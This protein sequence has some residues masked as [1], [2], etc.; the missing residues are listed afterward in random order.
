MRKLASIQRVRDVVEH[1]N[2]DAL[3]IAKV[4]GWQCIIKKGEMQQ[5]DLG[6]YF[7]IDSFLPANDE[8]YLFLEKTFRTFEGILGA[9]IKTIKLRGELSQGLILPLSSYPELVH[10]EEGT[11]VTE[12]LG[13]LKYE[14]P[15]PVS[16][17]AKGNFPGFIEKT[18]QE[19]IQNLTRM[20]RSG[21][22]EKTEKLD[23]SSLTVYLND[24]VFGVCS[25]NMELIESDT[26]PMWLIAREY[27]LEGKLR[28]LGK[29][30][31]L[32]GEIIGGKI[33]GNRYGITGYEYHIYDVYDIENKRKLL[34]E[35]RKNIIET[36]NTYDDFQLKEVPSFGY[37]EL[38]THDAWIEELLSDA[39]G[40]SVLNDKS[41]RE[42]FVYK[43]KEKNISFKVISNKFLLKYDE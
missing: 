3:E 36:L 8:R 20:D 6:V 21:L 7:E 9:R 41:I 32:Q 35:E 24:D 2:A 27:Q 31:A 19:R 1:S 37:V 38:P 28:L 39:D 43:H 26:N 42:G 18:D 33:Q 15:M 17:E 16:S 22:W 5:G 12:T 14:K 25:R 10:M 11:D 30:L 29:N 40:T 13:I 4:N 23:G 34:P